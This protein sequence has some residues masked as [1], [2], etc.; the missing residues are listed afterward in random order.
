MAVVGERVSAGGADGGVMTD[1]T[2]PKATVGHKPALDGMRGLGLLAVM[3]YHTDPSWIPGG[4]F[5][6]TMF[7]ALS[8]FLITSLLLVE[9]DRSGGIALKQFWFRRVR[10]LLPAALIALAGIILFGAWFADASQLQRLRGDVLSALVYVFNWR[11][12]ITNAGYSEAF[13]SA[14]PVQHFWSLAIE[15]QLYLVLPIVVAGVLAWRKGGRRLLAVVLGAGVLG[16]VLLSIQFSDL[17]D[18]TSR[19]Y[20][21]TDTRAAEFL[22]GAMLAVVLAGRPILT[23]PSRLKG[24]I[25]AVAA[26]GLIALCFR[27]SLDDPWVYRGGFALVAL[28]STVIVIMCWSLS[29]PVT[30]LLSPRPFRYLGTISYGMYLYHWPIYLTLTPERTDL[31]TWPLLGLRFAVTFAAAVVSYHL[32]ELPVRE[33]RSIISPR[34]VLAITSATAALVVGALIVTVEPPPPDLALAQF[35]G[36]PPPPTVLPQRVPDA[37]AV[38]VTTASDNP[39]EVPVALRPQPVRVMVVG[40]S[41]GWS[42]GIGMSGWADRSGQAAVWNV[43]QIGCGVAEGGTID[44][45]VNPCEEGIDTWPAKLAEYDPDIVVMLTGPWEL[46]DRRFDGAAAVEPGDEDFDEWLTSEFVRAADVLSARGAQVVW[47]TSP[48]ITETDRAGTFEGAEVFDPERTRILNE[49]IITAVAAQR[50]DTVA[51]RDLFG[52]LCPEGGYSG[53]VGPVAD[54]RPDGLHFADEAKPWLADWI[55][56][57]LLTDPIGV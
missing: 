40:D 20:Y 47:L 33:R 55:M 17:A 35:D 51:V 30:T 29:E 32:I 46:Y 27:T 6:L 14:S 1:Q 3:A 16:S 26:G 34:P 42:L 52:L 50:P 39:D 9:Q 49:E 28:L 8:G 37:S 31:S 10:R 41:L 44:T 53:Q 5:A 56:P 19:I 2:P 36:V 48:C 43:A 21:G 23:V 57:K 24:W 22:V 7:F 12:V 15:E 25:G 18:P 45:H 54:G 13:E 4:V 38:P 11:L